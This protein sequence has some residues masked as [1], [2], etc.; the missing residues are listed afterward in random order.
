MMIG[1]PLGGSSEGGV[2]L[3]KICT[4][5]TLPG[6][7]MVSKFETLKLYQIALCGAGL[8][9][10]SA[11]LEEIHCTGSL[12]DKHIFNFQ[13]Y[14]V[15]EKVWILTLLHNICFLIDGNSI[16]HTQV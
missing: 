11:K 8:A 10:E 1:L 12:I 6:L 4:F 14:K 2:A 9:W 5:L 16:L 13:R 3:I 15:A 7:R